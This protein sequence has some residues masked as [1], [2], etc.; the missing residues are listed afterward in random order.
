MKHNTK[1]EIMIPG[2]V[3]RTTRAKKEAKKKRHKKEAKRG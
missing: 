2:K 1:G 3:M